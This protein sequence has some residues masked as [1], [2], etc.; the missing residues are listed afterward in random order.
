MNRPEFNNYVGSQVLI[1]SGRVINHAKNDMVFLFGKKGVG[2]STPATFNVD[3]SERVL[4]A[5]PKIEL[6]YQAEVRGEPILLGRSTA[7][8]LGILLDNLKNLSDALQQISWVPEE[9][10]AATPA[11][12]AASKVLSDEAILVKN[13]LNSATCLSQTSYTR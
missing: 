6:G 10:A 13:Q 5:S 12:R 1:S 9:L 3:A 8:Q 7:N 2:I 11:I 4:I